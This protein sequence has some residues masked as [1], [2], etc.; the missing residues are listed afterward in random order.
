MKARVAV[1]RSSRRR[2]RLRQSASRRGA[3]PPAAR[4]VAHWEPAWR[5]LTAEQQFFN[6][7]GLALVVGTLLLY[8]LGG[9]VYGRLPVFL[10]VGFEELPGWVAVWGGASAWCLAAAWATHLADRHLPRLDPLRMARWRWRAYA[11]CA[12][13]LC[14]CVPLWVLGLLG[15]W[16]SLGLWQGFAPRSEWL[17][18]PL[19]W[20]WPWMLS[21]ARDDLHPWL[22]GTLLV[23]TCM[24]LWCFRAQKH[25]RAGLFLM[26]LVLLAVGLWALGGA[27]Y[28]YV[29]GRGLAGGVADAV[30]VLALQSRPG[31]RNADTFLW[32][33]SAWFLLALG[34]LVTAGALHIRP[35]A[36][37][38]TL[39]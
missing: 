22:L 17:L 39:P 14:V 37:R 20:A 11:A 28:H 3:Q 24:A 23:G 38:H 10:A 32:L 6:S 8:G 15:V 18:A 26:G 33:L 35:D 4:P 31:P 36:P 1:A 27:A 34:S 12:A 2:A 13:L 5:A 21:A 16:G 29:A 30:A 25:P 7:C 19:P 9:A